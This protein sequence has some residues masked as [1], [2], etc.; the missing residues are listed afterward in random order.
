MLKEKNIV[1]FIGGKHIFPQYHFNVEDTMRKHRKTGKL[2]AG[3]CLRKAITAVGMSM[4]MLLA[5]PGISELSTT[6]NAELSTVWAAEENETV[7]PF[8][9]LDT[10]TLVSEMGMGWNLGN[11]F[12]GH[13]GFT[14]NETVWQ[15]VTTTKECIQA[16]HDMGFNTVRIPVTWGN[17]IDDEDGYSIDE[18]WISRV[19]DVVD[20]CI[21]QD[22]YAIINIHHDGAEQ[23]GW[24]R[25]A[26]DDMD[27]LEEKYAGVWKTIAER[28]AGYDEHLI[29]ES[30]NEVKGENMTTQEENTIISNLN[31]IFVDTVRAS[32]GNNDKRFLVVT[33]KYNNIVSVTTEGNGF[34]MPTDTAENRLII[35]VHDYSPWSFCGQ[36]DLNTTETS[37]EQLQRNKEELKPLYDTY[38]SKGIPVIVGEYGCINKDNAEERAY[39]LEG[40]NRIYAQYGL[41][42]IYWDQGWYDRTEEPDYSFAI[43]DRATGETID[44][45]I[46]DAM[47]RG[48]W[49]TGSEDLSDIERNTSVVELSAITPAQDTVQLSVG[50]A[51]SID[52][53]T[54]PE[55]SNDVV[56]WKTADDSIA[57]V[58]NGKVRGKGQGTTTVTAFS[59]SGSVEA[60]ITVTVEAATVNGTET[61]NGLDDSLMLTAGEYTYLNAELDGSTDSYLYYVSGNTSVATVSPIGKVLAIGTGET[62]ITVKSS[63]GQTTEIPVTVSEAEEEH[64]IQLAINVYYN[65]SKNNFYQNEISQDVITVTKNG[66]YT[67]TFDCQRDLSSAAANAGVDS[68]TNLTAI[69]IKDNQVAQGAA[70]ASPLQSCDIQ[71]D[72]IV[73]DDQVLTITQTEPKSALKSS[74]IFDTNDPVNSWDGSAVEG[75][76]T[77]DHVINFTDIT[78]P[79]TI[80]IT[81][82]LSN[83]VYADGTVAED[84][85][86]ENA[87]T[88][89][90]ETI[91][92]E[93]IATASDA[94]ET[95]DSKANTGNARTAILICV[96]VVLVAVVGAA[97][98]FKKKKN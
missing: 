66:Q 58:Y 20:Y 34:T 25:I 3:G 90:T 97:C 94:A 33:G 68:L 80:E 17:M 59:Q 91:S 53:E 93:E 47:Q 70:S 45:T 38:T 23:T 46:T 32:G 65:D 1:L 77:S 42:G 78:N 44:K 56:L 85:T 39:Y 55:N 57:T 74:G 92:E 96:A 52:L 19:Q 49:C 6:G 98:M 14:P 18:A 83:I 15:N 43:V 41:V 81:F 31:Q 95:A 71:Y 7:M 64:S 82:T 84:T 27:G 2:A 54:L 61:I 28:F 9:E 24:L 73:V 10:A 48:F 69:Y 60:R 29:F 16:V 89:E 51:V 75:T 87:G 63:G 40:M 67:L 36:E 5:A 86:S 76:T 11:T 30:M 72:K 35:S 22:M 8:R 12:D 21:S 13:T 79:K 37:L 26:T 62:T 50:E 4:L 88:D